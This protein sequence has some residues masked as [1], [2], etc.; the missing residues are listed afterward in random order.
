MAVQQTALDSHALVNIVVGNTNYREE[1]MSLH[2]IL[3]HM[4]DS[5]CPAYYEHFQGPDE[6]PCPVCGIPLVKEG[7]EQ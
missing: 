4:W 6:F 7:K 3:I 5:G 2:Y 1:V